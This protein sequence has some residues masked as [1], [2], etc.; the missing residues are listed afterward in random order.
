M[1]NHLQSWPDM[2][3][4]GLVLLYTLLSNIQMDRGRLVQKTLINCHIE[5]LLEATFFKQVST[6]SL[7]DLEDLQPVQT[8]PSYK[9]LFLFL[10]EMS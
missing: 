8:K 1:G 4:N 6:W 9:D 7:Q 2:N 3:H 10:L 5:N